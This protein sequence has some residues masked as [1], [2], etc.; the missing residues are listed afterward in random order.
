VEQIS[1]TI[2]AAPT[3]QDSRPAEQAPA[4]LTGFR[5]RGRMRR[6]ARF[7]RKA[8]ELAYRDLGGLVFNLH[9]FSQ[10]NDELV[11]AKLGVLGQIDEE[12]R[13]LE[14]ALGEREPTT[15]LREAGITA[16]PRCAAIHAGEDRYC[17]NCGLSL[18]R[19]PDL[20]IAVTPGAGAPVPPATDPA[21]PIVPAG[22]AA[23]GETIS[24][25]APPVEVPETTQ[26][27]GPPA[28]GA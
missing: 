14:A 2:P 22:A 6:R 21:T 28:A 9:R 7:L 27:I 1:G 11:L 23:N 18:G 10:R 19:H 20:P 15:V 25:P 26:V 24:S 4:D 17:P 16:C 13:K 5:A 12:L 8:R 3:Q